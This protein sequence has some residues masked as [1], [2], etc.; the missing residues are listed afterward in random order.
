MNN[1]IHFTSDQ[2]R[3]LEKQ[4][5]TTPKLLDAYQMATMLLWPSDM[6]GSIQLTLLI[7]HMRVLN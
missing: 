1:P 3:Q 7:N 6:L 5:V 2:N 4:S